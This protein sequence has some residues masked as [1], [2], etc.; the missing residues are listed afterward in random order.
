MKK[1]NSDSIARLD[2]Y[3]SRNSKYPDNKNYNKEGE[4]VIKI[5]MNKYKTK[6]NW[7][8]PMYTGVMFGT[9]KYNEQ[10]FYSVE[11][12]DLSGYGVEII[13]Y[14]VLEVTPSELKELEENDG[15]VYPVRYGP[16]MWEATRWYMNDIK[17]KPDGTRPTI[18][19][20]LHSW[21]EDRATEAEGNVSRPLDECDPWEEKEEVKHYNKEGEEVIKIEMPDLPEFLFIPEG[22]AIPKG[23]SK[24]DFGKRTAKKNGV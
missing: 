11:N 22:Q 7:Y 16:P 13:V 20:A 1:D 15:C 3:T 2:F 8:E 17:D 6:E 9:Y 21:Y 18:E 12:S 24:V 4:E 10:Y 19:E 14:E 23:Y 5:D